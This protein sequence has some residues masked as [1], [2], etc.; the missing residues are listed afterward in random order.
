MS[1]YVFCQ[2]ISQRVFN[3]KKFYCG[4]LKSSRN[5]L[6]EY[7]IKNG[8]FHLKNSKWLY[9]DFGDATQDQID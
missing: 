2:F 3:Q 6:K 9:P 7:A 4:I 5:Q 1:K 8:D